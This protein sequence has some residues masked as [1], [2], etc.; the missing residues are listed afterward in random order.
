MVQQPWPP[1]HYFRTALRK[2]LQTRRKT[3]DSLVLFVACQLELAVQTIYILVAKEKA[4]QQLYNR[5]YNTLPIANSANYINTYM[6]Q[7]PFCLIFFF[8]FFFLIIY[9]IYGFIW[10]VQQHTLNA[11]WVKKQHTIHNR[12]PR[13]LNSDQS[14]SLQLFSIT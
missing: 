12:W 11:L 8:L 2:R 5:I 4:G 6:Y 10:H 1:K 13:M 9:F 3:P 14:S 7:L